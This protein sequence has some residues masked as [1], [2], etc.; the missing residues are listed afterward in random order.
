MSAQQ[1]EGVDSDL[2]FCLLSS[3]VSIG[4]S[5]EEHLVVLIFLVAQPGFLLLCSLTDFR[6]MT[7]SLAAFQMGRF[8]YLSGVIHVF[9]L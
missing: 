7:D 6:L 2:V 5:S 1:T 9:V 4:V 8:P 3:P